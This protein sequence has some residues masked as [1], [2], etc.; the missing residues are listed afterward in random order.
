MPEITGASLILPTVRLKALRLAATLAAS[1]TVIIMPLVVPTSSLVGVPV[2]APVAAFNVAQLGL[3]LM[4]NVCV[5]S[6]SA[7]VTVGIKL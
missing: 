5:S 6:R 7:S 4:L 3:L 1:F 2:K